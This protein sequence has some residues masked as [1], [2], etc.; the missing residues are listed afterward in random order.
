M[1]GESKT[2][3]PAARL[4]ELRMQFPT[5]E[6]MR[7]RARIRVPRFAFD[8]VDGAAGQ[9]EEGKARN[10]AALDAIEMVPRRRRATP[11][12]SSTASRTTISNSTST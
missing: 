12:S 11:G 8:Y 7:R 5:V 6:D 4:H 2:A 9:I 3:T 1:A 10:A